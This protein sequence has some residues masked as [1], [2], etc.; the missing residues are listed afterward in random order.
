[1]GLCIFDWC[2]KRDLNPH[3]REKRILSPP[4]LPFRHQ[5]MLR[6]A[7]GVDSIETSGKCKIYGFFRFFPYNSA[8]NNQYYEIRTRPFSSR[9]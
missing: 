7:N 5:G 6:T 3:S 9:F 8:S 2:P 4:R 1:M